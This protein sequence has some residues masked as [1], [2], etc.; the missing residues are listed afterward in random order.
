LPA[1]GVLPPSNLSKLLV[2]QGLLGLLL[3]IFIHLI[4]F[5]SVGCSGK[6]R[7]VEV[8]FLYCFALS[9]AHRSPVNFMCIGIAIAIAI[10][11]VVAQRR[12]K[13]SAKLN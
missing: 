6:G 12:E 3:F 10:V 7:F 1:D 8:S 2:E 11:S 9:L 5:R 4:C 13:L